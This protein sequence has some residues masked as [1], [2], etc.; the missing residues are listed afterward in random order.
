VIQLIH[1]G[2]DQCPMMTVYSVKIRAT[3]N[4]AG[5]DKSRSPDNISSGL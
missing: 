1:I 2:I 3:W 5:E 4:S